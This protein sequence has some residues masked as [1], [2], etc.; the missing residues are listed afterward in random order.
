MLR[1]RN[2]QENM[3]DL[4]AILIQNGDFSRR[5]KKEEGRY[6]RDEHKFRN[7]ARHAALVRTI[8]DP[9]REHGLIVLAHLLHSPGLQDGIVEVPDMIGWSPARALNAVAVERML[10]IV[11]DRPRS[12]RRR[13][14]FV[15]DLTPSHVVC[16]LKI[17]N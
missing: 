10:G 4:G 3:A 14:K 9:S 12:A 6:P 16:D 15:A 13:Q 17:G 7:S 1:M 5:L 2:I 8:C 11:D